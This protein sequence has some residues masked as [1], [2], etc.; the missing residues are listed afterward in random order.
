MARR[1]KFRPWLS[2]ALAAV[3]LV[4][5]GGAEAEPGLWVAKGPHAT[6]YLFGTVHVLRKDQVWA[7]PGIAQAFAASDELWLEVPDPENTNAAQALVA[8]F[9]FDQQ[10]PLS[11]KLPPADVAHLDTAAKTAGLREGEKAFEPTRPW[12]A[13]VMLEDAMIVHAGYDSAGG[14][15]RQLLHEAAARAKAV[16]GFETLDQQIHIFADMPQALEIELLQNTLQDFDQGAVKLDALVT[17]WLKGDDAA[18]AKIMVDEIRQPF[19]A[20]YRSILVNR[21]EAWAHALTQMLTGSGVKF[22]AVGAA[23]LAGDDSVQALLRR[24]GVTVDRVNRPN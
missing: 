20:L 24:Q 16:H 7:S 10:H 4:A 8:Q 18:I 15:E 19:P 3:L 6:I 23:H 21:N 1:V 17:A 13:S 12:L 5:A 9:G 22:V 11:T 2:I 14:V